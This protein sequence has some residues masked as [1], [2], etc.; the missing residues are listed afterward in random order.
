MTWLIAR[1]PGIVHCGSDVPA[2][3]CDR[4][5]RSGRKSCGDRRVGRRRA[6]RLRSVSLSSKGT[7]STDSVRVHRDCAPGRANVHGRQADDVRLPPSVH[8][9]RSVTLVDWLRCNVTADPRALAWF[10]PEE[11]E[12]RIVRGY[13][14]LL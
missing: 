3:R 8:D 14:E 7:P 6:A 12:G 5:I 4:G 13:R 10:D 1:W 2:G 11:A 9:R